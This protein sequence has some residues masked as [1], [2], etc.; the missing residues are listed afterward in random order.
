MITVNVSVTAQTNDFYDD[1][2]T[3]SLKGSK[4]I[5]VTGEVAREMTIDLNKLPL[6]S[7]TVK[8]TALT[9]GAVSF[10]GAYRYD[11]YSLYDILDKIVLKKK[12]EAEFPPIIDLYVEVANEEGESVTF[13]WGEIYYPVNR[14]RIMIATSV[15]RIVPSKSKDLWPLPQQTR[16]IAGND[17]ITERNI[18]NPVRITVRSLDSRYEINKNMSPMFS[19]TMRICVNGKQRSNLSGV[20]GDRQ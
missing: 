7:I 17:L 12:N 2:P 14:H 15:A 8:E 20:A 10:V 6:H 9:D 5:L 3:T 1:A 18:S 11:G 13:S 16:V 19:E 4:K